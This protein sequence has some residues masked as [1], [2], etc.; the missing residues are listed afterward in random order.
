MMSKIF[1]DTLKQEN[2]ILAKFNAILKL[3]KYYNNLRKGLTSGKI[4]HFKPKQNPLISEI[5]N[6]LKEDDLKLLDF[7][8]KNDIEDFLS[9]KKLKSHLDFEQKINSLQRGYNTIFVE[10]PTSG[11]WTTGKATFYIP[12]KKEFRNKIAI[13]FHSIPP[14]Q[15]TIYFEKKNVRTFNIQKLS[16]KE[17]DFVLEP[18]HITKPV[19]EISVTTDKLWLPNVVLG[20]KESLT[21]GIC[22]KSIDVSYF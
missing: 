7:L 14:I 9:K 21:L 20:V 18:S 6:N 19:S 5:I 13:K 17:V 3:W 16:T 8:F 15:V 1:H 12:T 2:G 10:K 11:L 4:Y 22:I